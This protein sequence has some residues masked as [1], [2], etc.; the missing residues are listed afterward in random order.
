MEIWD[1]YNADGTLSGVDIVRGEGVPQGLYHLVCEVLVRHTD[2]DYLLMQRDLSKPMY[3][4]RYEATAGGSAVKGEN[5]LEC[6]RREL[7]EETG[8]VCD[9][10]ELVVR[11]VFPED[12][13]I[14]DSYVCTTDCD[15]NSVTLQQG[16]TMGYKWISE[17]EF[18]RFVNS[19]EIID[20]QKRRFGDYYRKKGYLH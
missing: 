13:S 9:S 3:G 2:G 19:D 12:R 8:V 6:I 10:F 1:G 11:H 17:E 16:E 4:G 5:S 15:K 14:F 18:I 7:R 20:R